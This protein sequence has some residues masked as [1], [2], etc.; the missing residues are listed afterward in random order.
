M[1]P[2]DAAFSYHRGDLVRCACGNPFIARSAS[3]AC[4]RCGGRDV[5]ALVHA[6]APA[7]TPFRL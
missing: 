5:R 3:V 7:L 2:P 4:G 6:R 1:L